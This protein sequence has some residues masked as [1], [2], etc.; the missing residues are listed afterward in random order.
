MKKILMLLFVMGTILCQPICSAEL[1]YEHGYFKKIEAP[2]LEGWYPTHIK[3]KDGRVLFVYDRAYIFDPKTDKFTKGPSTLNWFPEG[4]IRIY[5]GILLDD[6]Q[7]LLRIWQRNHPMY[8][9]INFVNDVY[10][11]AIPK[12]DPF[13]TKYRDYSNTSDLPCLER[14][15]LLLPY[16]NSNKDLSERYNSDKWEYEFA[17]YALLYNPETGTVKPVGKHSI[18]RQ[19]GGQILLKDGRVLYFGGESED[20]PTLY[21]AHKEIQAKRAS[22]FEIYAPKTEKTSLLSVYRSLGETSIP[23]NFLLR[24]GRVFIAADFET[25]IYNPKNGTFKSLPMLRKGHNF[26]EL[27]DGT[28]IYNMGIP[29]GRDKNIYDYRLVMSYNP[30]TDEIKCL[31][32]LKVI[33]DM[34][35]EM[36]LLPDGNV[37][38]TGGSWFTGTNLANWG[39]VYNKRVEIFNPKTGMSK[40]VSKMK[41]SVDKHF[42]VILDDGRILFYSTYGGTELYIPKGYEEKVKLKN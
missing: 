5:G 37:M 10:R 13:R 26:L 4:H 39:L 7:V 30:V 8:H 6:G 32:K 14:E 20:D 16:I 40:V 9:N 2:E 17:R 33:R 24:D 18:S 23:E 36:L 35:F 38:V 29:N 27:D 22:Q 34:D 25:C 31:G 1:D 15:K 28:I 3:L 42:P 41:S 21:K 12:E 19:L 11:L